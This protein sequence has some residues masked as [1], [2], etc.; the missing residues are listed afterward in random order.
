MKYCTCRTVERLLSHGRISAAD[1]SGEHILHIASNCPNS[2]IIELLTGQWPSYVNIANEDG[3]S[4][5]HVASMYGQLSAIQALIENGADP[6]SMDSEGMTPLDYSLKEGHLSCVDY[7]RDLGIKPHSDDDDEIVEDDSMAIA[8]TLME[9]TILGDN[10]N[11]DDDDDTTLCYTVNDV[12]VT[13]DLDEFTNSML[14]AE[15]VKMGEKP[16]PINDLTRGAYLRYLRKAKNGL[17]PPQ[18]EE[19]NSKFSDEQYQNVYFENLC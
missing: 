18:T 6:F 4:P 19:T 2:K 13:L 15:L 9:T 11:D 7:F 12:D 1:S 8:Y 5:L 3:I 17:L 10:Y 14:R 16:G